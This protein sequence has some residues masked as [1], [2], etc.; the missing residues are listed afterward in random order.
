MNRPYTTLFI[1]TSL[2]GKISTGDTDLLD[3]DQDYKNISGLR[4]GLQQYYDIEMKTDLFS[5][6]T[7]RVFA[8]IGINEKTDEPRKLPVSYVVIDNEPHLTANGVKHLAKKSK[9]IIIV[10]TNDSHPFFAIKEEYSNIE[11]I[12]YQKEIDFQNLFLKLK[13]EYGV[14][15]MT[16]QSGGTLNTTL[17]REGLIDRVLLAVA[18]ALIGGK[19]TPTIMDGESIHTREDLF[20]IKTLELVQ[21]KPLEHSYLLLEYKVKN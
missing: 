6:N 17:I 21:A 7:G 13:N 18:P 5:L 3:V 14:E 19:D 4:E 8:K 1:L 20:K 9:K 10:T 11:I 12:L 16:V 15:K 2:D